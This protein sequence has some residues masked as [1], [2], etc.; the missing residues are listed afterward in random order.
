MAELVVSFFSLCLDLCISSHTVE[1]TEFSQGAGITQLHQLHVFFLS[2]QLSSSFIIELHIFFFWFCFPAELLVTSCSF[3]LCPSWHCTLQI[4]SAEPHSATV[5][6]HRNK[7]EK[8]QHLPQR[9]EGD[10]ED[11]AI[12]AML[13]LYVSPTKAVSSLTP[14]LKPIELHNGTIVYYCGVTF[15][16]TDC[17]SRGVSN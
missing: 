11:N 2:D 6:L 17:W 16:S 4:S 1:F 3:H 13:S 14:L 15:Q 9:P 5:M 12:P 10:R 8:L 7:E